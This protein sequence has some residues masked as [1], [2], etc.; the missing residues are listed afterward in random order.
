[1]YLFLDSCGGFGNFRIVASGVIDCG[2][3]P[4]KGP[5]CGVGG[6][7]RGGCIPSGIWGSLW[8]VALKSNCCGGVG[9]NS[10]GMS[11]WGPA[12]DGVSF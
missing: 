9:C 2:G 6:K 4:L 7:V 1:M 10:G 5:S 12:V 8:L 3:E 11:A